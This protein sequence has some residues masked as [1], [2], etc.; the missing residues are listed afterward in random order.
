MSSRQKLCALDT[1]PWIFFHPEN[2]LLKICLKGAF[3]LP[4]ILPAVEITTYFQCLLLTAVCKEKKI[5]PDDF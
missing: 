1:T 4:L 2:K 3:S 5:L